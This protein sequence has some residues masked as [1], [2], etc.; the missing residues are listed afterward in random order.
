MPGTEAVAK[1]LLRPDLALARKQW[2]SEVPN[3]EERAERERS[4]FLSYIDGD[5]RYAMALRAL[6][7]NLP[8]SEADK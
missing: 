5:G 3:P 2:I 7:P 8:S 4:D 6:G 1:R